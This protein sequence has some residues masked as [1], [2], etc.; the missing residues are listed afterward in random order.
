MYTIVAVPHFFEAFINKDEALVIVTDCLRDNDSI[1]L[2][3]WQTTGVHPTTITE[4]VNSFISG[5][6]LRNS[7]DNEP[8]V[9]FSELLTVL[10]I[11]W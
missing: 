6:K 11:S 10:M 7:R 1:L 3:D 8:D 4:R 5:K 2:S 9:F